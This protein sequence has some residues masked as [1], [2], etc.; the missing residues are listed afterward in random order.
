MTLAPQRGVRKRSCNKGMD[1]RRRERQQR[2]RRLRETFLD[3]A[4]EF[5]RVRMAVLRRRGSQPPDKRNM[6]PNQ[7]P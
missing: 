6:P 7:T 5:V 4:N 3:L 1:H 2:Q